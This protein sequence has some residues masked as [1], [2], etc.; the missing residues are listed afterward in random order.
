MNSNDDDDDIEYTYC[1]MCNDRVAVYLIDEADTCDK[2]ELFWCEDCNLGQDEKRAVFR[3][4]GIRRCLECTKTTQWK[5]TKCKVNNCA[6]AKCE[7]VSQLIL[8]DRKWQKGVCCYSRREDLCKGCQMWGAQRI[9]TT[10]I[11]IRKFRRGTFL[12]LL[13]RD[14]LIHCIIFK[15]HM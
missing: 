10:L 9:C 13:P 11:G 4:K 14:V 12:N 3:Y 1:S 7:N 15:L 5:C 6:S 2:C 8:R